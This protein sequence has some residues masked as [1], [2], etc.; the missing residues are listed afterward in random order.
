MNQK[1]FLEQLR[2]TLQQEI[3][4]LEF[5]LRYQRRW[6]VIDTR[7]KTWVNGQEVFTADFIKKLEHDLNLLKGKFDLTVEWIAEFLNK[8]IDTT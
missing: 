8:K 2:D 6:M 4:K 7:K 3:W 5:E 1:L